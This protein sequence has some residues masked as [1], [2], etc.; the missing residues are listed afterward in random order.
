[1]FY[2]LNLLSQNI[3]QRFLGAGTGLSGLTASTHL[4]SCD[5]AAAPYTAWESV[6]SR[7][8]SSPL[9]LLILLGHFGLKGE[10]IAFPCLS[11]HQL[12]KVPLS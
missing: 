10:G 9:P 8:S 2:Y 11:C 6:F 4:L 12:G 5:A 3:H 1:M 7:G